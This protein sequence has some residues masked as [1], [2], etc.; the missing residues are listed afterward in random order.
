MGMPALAFEVVFGAFGVRAF[1][2]GILRLAGV[3]P[4]RKTYFGAIELSE[5]HRA[6]CLAKVRRMAAA[7]I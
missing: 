7:A 1:A 3:W 6:N 2:R 5:R 4:V